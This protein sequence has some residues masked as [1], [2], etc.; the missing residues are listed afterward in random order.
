M[1]LNSVQ[2]EV[3]KLTCSDTNFVTPLSSHHVH[4]LQPLCLNISNPSYNKT[5]KMHSFLKF[6]FGI[7]LYMFRTVSQSITSLALYTQQ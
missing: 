4:Q 6:I 7:E 3:W 5:N 2:P 1:Q